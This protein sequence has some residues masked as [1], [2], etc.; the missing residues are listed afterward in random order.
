[1]NVARARPDGYIESRFSL[2]DGERKKS[3][4]GNVSVMSRGRMCREMR[5]KSP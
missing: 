5:G 4:Y 2:L 3:T 1:M